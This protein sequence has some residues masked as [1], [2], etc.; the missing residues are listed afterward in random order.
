MMMT[1][2]D[3]PAAH[4]TEGLRLAEM[5]CQIVRDKRSTFPAPHTSLDFPVFGDV[6]S[7]PYNN[8]FVLSKGNVMLVLHPECRDGVD[9]LGVPELDPYLW[10]GYNLDPVVVITAAYASKVTQDGDAVNVLSRKVLNFTVSEKVCE[11]AR[12]A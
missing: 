5:L 6:Y 4:V 12:T 3:A 11:R 10:F 2:G 1:S 8:Y 9:A 7:D